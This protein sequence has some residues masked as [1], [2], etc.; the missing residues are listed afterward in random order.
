MTLVREENVSL[1]HKIQYVKAEEN[2]QKTCTRPRETGEMG[3]GVVS[4]ITITMPTTTM[5]SLILDEIQ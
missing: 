4:K 2:I 1:R 3:L 5:T